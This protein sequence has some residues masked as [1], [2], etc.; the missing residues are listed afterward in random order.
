MS[1]KKSL[2]EWLNDFYQITGTISEIS[3]NLAFAAIGLIWIFKNSEGSLKILPDHLLLP[4][5]LIVGNLILDFLQYIWLATLTYIVYKNREIKF[6]K[7]KISEKDI[8]DVQ[9]S[10]FYE[11][12]TFTFFTLKL[13]FLIWAY[14]LLSIFMLTKI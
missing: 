9:I 1:I 8:E 5:R 10:S 14:T 13:V 3:R 7:N 11:K 2:S 4:I 12:I 6:F